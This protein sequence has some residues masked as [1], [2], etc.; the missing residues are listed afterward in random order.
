VDNQ[1]RL[2]LFALAYNLGDFLRR[3]ALPPERETLV[4][5]NAEGEAGKDCRQGRNP[6]A[7]C[8]VSDGRGGYFE[9]TVQDHPSPNLTARD[10]GTSA[11]MTMTTFAEMG[12][13]QDLMERYV[14]IRTNS[15]DGCPRW[16]LLGRNRPPRGSVTESQS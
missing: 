11:D 16:L 1:V 14:R 4:A 3:L 9:T 15:S 10:T 7:V 6:L 5:D 13:V 12:T 2:Q 8:H